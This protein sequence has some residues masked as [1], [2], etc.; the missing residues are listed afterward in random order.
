MAQKKRAFITGASG[1]DGSY[2]SEYLL[3]LG[4][5]IG[6]FIRSS[7]TGHLGN[8]EHLR[9]ELKF[10]RGSLDDESSI[11]QAISA[12]E[13]DEIYNLGAEAAPFDSFKRPVYTSDI[14]AL[15]PLRIFESANRLRKRGKQVKVYQACHSE[16]TQVVTINGIKKYTELTEDDLILT[17]NLKNNKI[18]Y[19]R[20]SK[21]YEYDYV[22]EMYH[23]LSRR[24]DILVTP[25]H[26]MFLQYDGD[27]KLAFIEADK[28]GSLLKFPR[29]S[30]ISLPIPEWEGKTSATV[31]FSDY[32]DMSLQAVN[33][34]RNLIT[35]MNA[36]DFYYL[37]GLYIG[38]GYTQQKKRKTVS[39]RASA[40]VM[41][42]RDVQGRF[43]AVQNIEPIEVEYESNYIQLAIPQ[44][45]KARKKLI[46]VLKRN[47]LVFNEHKI[48]V[49]LSSVYLARMFKLAGENVYTKKIPP[50]MLLLSKDLLKRLF[51]G[52]IDS[53]GYSRRTVKSGG[54]RYIYTTVSHQLVKDLVELSYKLGLV[55]SIQTIPAGIKY[56]KSEKRYVNS[57]NGFI[58][59]FQFKNK[60]KIYKKNILKLDYKG[61]VWCLE[62]E[63]N[64][65]FLTVRNGKFAFTGNSTSEMFGAPSIVPQNE[66]T[67]MIP[68]NPYGVA[69]LFA[70]LQARILR[71]GNEKLPIWCGIL[72]NHESPR[73]GMQYV[74]RK[75]TVAV[76]CIKN[77]VKNPPLNEL[78]VPIITK[79]FKLEMGNLDAKR[80]WGYAKEYVELMHKMLQTDVP[81]EYV[82]ATNETHT[83]RE[84]VEVAFSHVGLSWQDYVVTNPDFVRPLET[85]PLCGDYSKAKEKLGFKPQVKF[86]Q[87][88]KMMVDADLARFS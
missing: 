54:K 14:N 69:K 83:I 36:P 6:A 30:H 81:D 12:F 52:L 17:I 58:I 23:F 49:E 27:N 67:P 29:N 79:D 61:K 66:K 78:G 9:D 45:D 20:F 34:Y 60:N 64:H 82:I 1:Q 70:H 50:W 73:R 72:F 63:D 88:I 53:D 77:K 5:E 84:L 21:I 18:E 26:K 15:G 76:A 16:D 38:D 44:E 47:N 74:T 3:G 4:Y 55:P 80:D 86:E 65:N 85:G 43:I 37:M 46:E 33:N 28:V 19:K 41:M 8:I 56:F 22:G 40:G 59:S 57:S 25:N 32:I 62:V 31:V 48:T 24:Q 13:P 51:E 11:E 10:F 7:S 2:L 68:A 39:F 42:M 71:E 35:E 75:V 87:L